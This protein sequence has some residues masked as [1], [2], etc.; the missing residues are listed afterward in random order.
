ML[1]ATDILIDRH[2][3][4]VLLAVERR[5]LKLRRGE[6]VEVPTRID[7]GVER[8]GLALG[9]AAALG[10]GDVLP[11]RMAVERVARLVEI[12]ILGQLDRQVLFR[13]RHDAA[14]LAMDRRDR[15]APVA[16]ARH[17]PVTQA[18]LRRAL[19]DADL[20]QSGDDAG[21]GLLDVEA[22]Q[23][24]G[25]LPGINGCLASSGSL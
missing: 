23:E 6:P 14:L 4:I 21:L 25:V 20:F 22:V 17:Q 1:D 8:V 10:T 15:T 16:L 18:V 9:G 11:G 3:V 5:R 24:V 19:A 12:D 7:E 13:H 2:P